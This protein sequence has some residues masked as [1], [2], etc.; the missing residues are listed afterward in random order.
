M[1]NEI[2]LTPKRN[3]PTSLA[4]L[5]GVYDRAATVN[6]QHG[7][8][9][10][11]FNTTVD[12]RKADIQR[13]VESITDLKRRDEAAKLYAAEHED[14]LKSYRKETSDS[15]WKDARELTTLREDAVA[16]RSMFNPLAMATSYN[17][18][19]PKR[20]AIEASLNGLGKMALKNIADRARLEGDK[21]TLAALVVTIDKMPR[22]DRPPITSQELAE[23]G[24]GAEAAQASKLIA[25][26]DRLH[27]QAVAAVRET[28]G[29]KLSPVQQVQHG[30]TYGSGRAV[31]VSPTVLNKPRTGTTKISDALAS[32]DFGG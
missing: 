32:H 27:A 3:V 17:L 22:G 16:S 6:A 15:R 24:F 20:S 14:W 21:D 4:H 10:V 18:G 23:A 8:Q 30:M 26:I 11:A 31:P 13:R 9:I 5:K 1:P 12:R 2:E 25:D 19:Q 7:R 28:E 29:Q